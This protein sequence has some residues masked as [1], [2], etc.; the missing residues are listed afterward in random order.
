MNLRGRLTALEEKAA[1]KRGGSVMF[2]EGEDGTI[3][4]IRQKT[5]DAIR[6]G[7][8][9]VLLFTDSEPREPWPQSSSTVVLHFDLQDAGL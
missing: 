7:R 1:A 8:A 9:M 3:D 5:A 2:I 6:S 4:D